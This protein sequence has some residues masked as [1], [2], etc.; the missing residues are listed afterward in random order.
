[1]V[2]KYR[3]Q[4]IHGTR[5]M[6][7]LMG[8]FIYCLVGA[9]LGLALADALTGHNTLYSVFWGSISQETLR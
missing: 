2:T 4:R 3:R 7:M 6:Q 9:L 1:M 8:V 5:P